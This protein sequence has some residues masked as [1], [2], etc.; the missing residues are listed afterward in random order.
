MK[1]SIRIEIDMEQKMCNDCR[2]SSTEYYELLSQIRVLYFE[3]MYEI[4]SKIFKVFEIFNSI[5]KIEEVDNGFDIYFRHHGEMN[6]ISKLLEKNYLIDEIRSK[7][8]V[9]KNNLKSV[10]VFRYYQS[11]TLVN[12]EK[13]DKILLKGEE[14]IIKAINNNTEL[15][16]LNCLT[17]A[18]K[19]ITYNIV[20]DYIKLLE[21]H[22]NNK[23]K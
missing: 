17:G 6:K 1:D 22:S 15:V 16:L 11:V 7:K 20:K 10:D 3:D 9:G 18:K 2:K 12:I 19:A 13:G 4:K 14:F 8:L 5:N 21:K 23:T